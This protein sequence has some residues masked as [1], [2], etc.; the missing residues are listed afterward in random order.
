MKM[1]DTRLSGTRDDV[2]AEIQFD[3]VDLDLAFQDGQSNALFF[4]IFG[5]TWE[6]LKISEKMLAFSQLAA[7]AEAGQASTL[8][9]SGTIEPKGN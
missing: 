1:T 6:T 4:R 9:L 3:N 8:N 7:L 5:P 2:D